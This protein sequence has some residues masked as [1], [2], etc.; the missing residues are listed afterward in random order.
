MGKKRY[1]DAKNRPDYKEMV[2]QPEIKNKRNEVRRCIFDAKNMVLPDFTHEPVY[3]RTFGCGQILRLE[4][5]RYGDKC[6]TCSGNK[7]IDPTIFIKL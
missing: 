2:V 1:S 5:S 6:F 3:C 4:E 7:K